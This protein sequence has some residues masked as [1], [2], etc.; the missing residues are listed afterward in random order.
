MA[1]SDTYKNLADN[2][3]S[4]M[5]DRGMSD[6][7]LKQAQTVL[8]D[9]TSAD[10]GVSVSTKLFGPI[11]KAYAWSRYHVDT[12]DYIYIATKAINDYVTI[13]LGEDLTTFVNDS[14][15]WDYGCVPAQWADLSERSDA[16]IDTSDWVVCS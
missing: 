9:L 4:M 8:T 6:T 11:A 15:P 5:L 13:T 1:Y 10:N 7:Y 2:F 12:M 14:V 3:N 16:S